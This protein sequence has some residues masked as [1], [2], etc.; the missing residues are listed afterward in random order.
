[1]ASKEEGVMTRKFMHNPKPSAAWGKNILHQRNTNKPHDE[2]EIYVCFLKVLA[3]GRKGMDRIVS[4][5][6]FPRIS[7][8]DVVDI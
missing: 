2:K 8:K 6:I 3:R 4:K 7:L 5:L 1:M